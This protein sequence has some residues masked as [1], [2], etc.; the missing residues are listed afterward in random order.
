MVA[1]AARSAGSS[2][3]P[4]CLALKKR[5][6]DFQCRIS[7]T[8]NLCGLG[9]LGGHDGLGI[10]HDGPPSILTSIIACIT[11]VKGLNYYVARVTSAR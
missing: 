6:P 3:K 5:E 2:E 9:G 7:C 1:F 4:C 8:E 11:A 10:G